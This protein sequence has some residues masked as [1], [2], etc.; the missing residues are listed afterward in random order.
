M[1]KPH[2]IKL[3]LLSLTFFLAGGGQTVHAQAQLA[4]APVKAADQSST[5]VVAELKQYVVQTEAGKEVLKPAAAV[6]PGDVIEYRVTYTNRGKALVRDVKAEL[7]I[8]QGLEYISK[9]ARPTQ[10]AEAAVRGGAYAREPLM[11]DAAGGK[12][13]PV[14]Y[15]EY[16]SLRWTLGQIP[17]GAKAE[18]SARA[19]VPAIVP[20]SNSSNTPAA[21]PVAPVR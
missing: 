13:E 14:P 3:L 20:V 19:R 17:A 8:P 10:S 15:G 2:S 16:R 6:K 21:A 1:L 12:K 5:A 9:S 7:P 18:V 11:R 4:D